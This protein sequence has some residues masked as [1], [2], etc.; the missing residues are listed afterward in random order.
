M[1]TTLSGF[2]KDCQVW[3]D[4]LPAWAEVAS[5]GT[6]E[7]YLRWTEGTAP[8]P[9]PGRAAGW[10]F[11]VGHGGSASVGVLGASYQPHDYPYI[12][13]GVDVTVALGRSGA[14]PFNQVHSGLPHEYAG[15]VLAGAGQEARALGPGVVRFQWAAVHDVDSSWEAFRLLAVG[16]MRLLAVPSTEALPADLLPYFGGPIPPPRPRHRPSKMPSSP[17][18]GCKTASVSRDMQ[19]AVKQ[20]RKRL[21]QD[22]GSRAA[23]ATLHEAERRLA[24]SH[25]EAWAQP[26]DLGVMWDAGAPLPHLLSNG[27]RAV[28][29][30][31]AARV[32]PHWDGT[33]TTVVSP[34]DQAPSDMLEFTFSGCQA[35][36][37]GGPNDEALGGHPLHSRGLDATDHTSYTTRPG[38]RSRRRSTRS[39]RSTKVRVTSG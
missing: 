24:E 21:A 16:V 3:V 28:L 13:I 37:L 15:A 18:R 39:T 31:H 11:R 22:Y 4:D 9:L 10:G 12:R 19:R 26:L 30:C 20:A 32:N 25:N 29:L 7:T 8:D 1:Q 34:S 5:V 33:Y 6:V 27:S 2:A 35:V 36:R 23:W 38:S 14:R 17:D